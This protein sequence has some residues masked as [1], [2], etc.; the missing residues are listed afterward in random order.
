MS[1]T[2]MS[3][4]IRLPGEGQPIMFDSEEDGIK[5]SAEDALKVFFAETTGPPFALWPHQTDEGI[6]E[7]AEYKYISAPKGE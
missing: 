1:E 6:K 4:P 5:G 7:A 3:K 2:R